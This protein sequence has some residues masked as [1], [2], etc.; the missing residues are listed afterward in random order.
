[1]GNES[2]LTRRGGI[3]LPDLCFMS[4]VGFLTTSEYQE[5]R[6]SGGQSVPAETGYEATSERAAV[7]ALVKAGGIRRK[8][9]PKVDDGPGQLSLFGD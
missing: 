3:K 5:W 9:E 8:A 4:E 7:E 2:V 1:M 6:A